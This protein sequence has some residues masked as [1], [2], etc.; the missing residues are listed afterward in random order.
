MPLTHADDLLCLQLHTVG[1]PYAVRAFLSLKQLLLV[2]SL[3]PTQSP[4]QWVSALY[5]G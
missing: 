3:G 4:V 5:W 1:S 2:P